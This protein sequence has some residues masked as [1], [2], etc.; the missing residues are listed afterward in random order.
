MIAD[1]VLQKK[2]V[3]R[4]MLEFSP[5]LISICPERLTG[6]CYAG[7]LC[8]LP[9]LNI[10][11]CHHHLSF[12]AALWLRVL[13][14]PWVL[15]SYFIVNLLPGSLTPGFAYR[16]QYLSWIGISEVTSDYQARC[17]CLSVATNCNNQLVT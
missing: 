2:P 7:L 11:S 15:H 16:N 12:L 10:S 17:E 14:A 3:E 13:V 4:A 9:S 5:V 1:I 6:R 8:L